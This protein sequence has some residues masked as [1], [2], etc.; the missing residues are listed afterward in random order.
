VEGAASGW[1]DA[2]EDARSHGRRAAI[3]MIDKILAS[4]R[5]KQKDFMAIDLSET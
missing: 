5:A 2:A 4:W 1:A 3:T